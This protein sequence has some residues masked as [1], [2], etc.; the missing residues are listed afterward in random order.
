MNRTLAIALLVA[1]PMSAW[2]YY[3]LYATDVVAAPVIEP[4]VRHFE[5]GADIDLDCDE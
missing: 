1:V 5:G 4:T 3:G 2:A